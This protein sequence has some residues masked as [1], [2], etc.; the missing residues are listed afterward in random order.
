MNEFIMDK[1][2]QAAYFLWEYTQHDNP[3]NHWYCAEDI[4][5]FFEERGIFNQ[6]AMDGIT[7]GGI[8][9]HTYIDFMRHIAFRIFIYTNQE[10]ALTN[11]FAGERLI[12]NNEWCEA[13]FG[14]TQHYS[15]EKNNADFM[16]SLRSD[17]VR[18]FYHTPGQEL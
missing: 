16:T 10:N 18:R 8:Y 11:W 15:R 5:C 3:L 7:R 1:T 2:K 4:A 13:M 12:A 6:E 14:I 17:K 9:T